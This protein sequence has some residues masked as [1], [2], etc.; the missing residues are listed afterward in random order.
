MTWIVSLSVYSAAM[1]GYFIVLRDEGG[2]PL[3]GYHHKDLPVGE[4]FDGRFGR[5]QGADF[6]G[7]PDDFDSKRY[8][9]SNKA[10]LMDAKP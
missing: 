7:T 2:K 8:T 1:G 5:L 3:C 4:V 6:G 9:D 10:V